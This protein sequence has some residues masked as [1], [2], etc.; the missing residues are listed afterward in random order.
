MVLSQVECLTES[1][2][3]AQVPSTWLVNM[4]LECRACWTV[5]D[6]YKLLGVDASGS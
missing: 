2:N 3:V 4:V 6:G 1:P 5:K